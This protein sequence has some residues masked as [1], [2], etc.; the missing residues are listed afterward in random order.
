M[1]HRAPA[2]LIAIRR[3][4]KQLLSGS[5]HPPPHRAI[6]VAFPVGDEAD[7]VAGHAEPVAALARV[8][9][10]LGVRFRRR[11]GTSSEQEDKG[12]DP[13]IPS[14]PE[15]GAASSGVQAKG[16]KWRRLSYMTEKLG[17]SGRTC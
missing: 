9:Q 10:S 15:S 13:H 11:W 6:G 7:A 14:S 8:E 12:K 16:D 1:P 3:D 2:I 4:G 17:I 5:I